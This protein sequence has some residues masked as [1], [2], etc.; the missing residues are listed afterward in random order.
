MYDVIGIGHPLI[1]LCINTDE[2]FLDKFNLTKGGMH[3]FKE[4]EFKAILAEIDK[5]KVTVQFGGSVPNTIHG[6]KLLGCNVAEYGKVGNDEYGKKKA[7]HLVHE[8][9]E[10]LLSFS[11]LPTGTVIALVT[12]EAQRTFVVYLGAASDLNEADIDDEKIKQAKIIH[13]TGYEFE[14]PN[15]RKAINKAVAIAKANKILVSFDLADP[16]V[17]QRNF[18]ELRDFIE[19]NVNILFA[20]EEE[21]EEY[22]GKPATEAGEY[23]SKFVDYA[24]IKLGENGSIIVTRDSGHKYVFAA[25]KIDAVDTTGAGDIYAAGILYG[26]AKDIPLDKAGKIASYAAARVVERMGARLETLDISKFE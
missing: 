16:G 18:V 14:S 9:I 20:N 13:F 11:G 26:I 25:E 8:K 7:D 4:K 6:L 21:A 23:F 2:A 5:S 19:N 1:D 22:T 12:E 10:N 24:V 3:L 15:V 17:I